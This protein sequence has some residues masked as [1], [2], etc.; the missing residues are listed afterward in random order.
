LKMD[1]HCYWTGTCIGFFN[2]KYYLF[3]LFFGA[4]ATGYTC[5][6]N[7]FPFFDTLFND[8]FL[9]KDWFLL[10]NYVDSVILFGTCNFLLQFHLTIL[11]SNQTTIEHIQ[12]GE[13][14]FDKGCMPNMKEVFGQNILFWM[15]P[16]PSSGD[17]YYETSN[18]RE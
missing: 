7:F 2:Y 3:L 5:F 10:L 6:S 13:N 1:H 11:L 12:G 4:V 18:K 16:I 8:Y 9:E 15:L 14:I 17:G